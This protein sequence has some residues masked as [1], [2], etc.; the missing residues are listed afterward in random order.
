M[1][2]NKIAESVP[3]YIARYPA[4]VQKSL[5]KLRATIKKAAPKAKEVISYGI[6]AYK[7]DEPLVYFAAYAKHIGFY[8]TSTGIKA[9]PKELAKYKTS[10]GAV[11]F[12]ID[13]EIPWTLVTK[14]VKHRISALQKKA[15]LKKAR[16]K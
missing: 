1:K 16:K 13:E 9:F 8:P 14:I 15:L 12:P 7:M 3:E 6:P 11:Q 5:K 2:E 4:S 10:K